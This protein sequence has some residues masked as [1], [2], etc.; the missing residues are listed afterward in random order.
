MILRNTSPIPIGLTPGDLFGG[1]NWLAMSAS[2]LS[3]QLSF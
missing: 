2:K 3:W 1:I